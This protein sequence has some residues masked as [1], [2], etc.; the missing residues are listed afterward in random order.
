MFG[1]GKSKPSAEESDLALNRTQHIA[2]KLLIQ[3]NRKKLNAS[4]EAM[5]KSKQFYYV[6]IAYTAGTGAP[7]TEDP[8]GNCVRL[9]N[10]P[11]SWPLKITKPNP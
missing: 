9:T 11:E 10:R 3:E 5:Q 7:G 2:A 6:G 8:S 4:M 1:F